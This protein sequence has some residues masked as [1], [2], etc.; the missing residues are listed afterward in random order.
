MQA[1]HDRKPW[2]IKSNFP[3]LSVAGSG[4]TFR[5][6]IPKEIQHFKN[7]LPPGVS[8]DTPGQ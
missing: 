6:I 2:K 3:A 4:S 7:V 5:P 8:V 1:L